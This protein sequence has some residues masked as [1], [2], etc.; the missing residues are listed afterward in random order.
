M[1]Y[2]DNVT[3]YIQ[4]KFTYDTKPELQPGSHMRRGYVG[5]CKG[6]A[7]IGASELPV[8]GQKF[9]KVTSKFKVLSVVKSQFSKVYVNGN[10]LKSKGHLVLLEPLPP[11][12]ANQKRITK[13]YQK[14][15]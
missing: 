8:A 5:I 11:T 7:N 1:A 15:S 9:E 14:E 3:I 13:V 12:D 4:S 2:I 6:S 10:V